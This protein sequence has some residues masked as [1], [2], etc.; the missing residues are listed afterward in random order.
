MLHMY[1]T[2]TYTNNIYIMGVWL[3]RIIGGRTSVAPN[4]IGAVAPKCTYTNFLLTLIDIY[5]YTDRHPP[6][7][8]RLGFKF[9]QI[10]L[11]R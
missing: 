8:R 2:N 11:Y 5:M 9:R 6:I 1:I 3:T 10:E 7:S 4:T